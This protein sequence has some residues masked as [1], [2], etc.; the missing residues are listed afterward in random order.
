MRQ[1]LWRRRALGLLVA[2][3]FW[4]VPG[5]SQQDAAAPWPQPLSL[6]YVLAQVD[7]SHP[8]LEL[9]RAAVAQAQ[10]A[11]LDAQASY[12]F[13]ASLVAQLRWVDPPA[14]AP[15]QSQGDHRV[16]LYL[17]QRLYDFGRTAAQEA[18][19]AANVAGSQDRYRYALSQY[20]LAV[21][22]AFFDVILA[23]LEY[24]RDNEDM[25]TA[26]VQ[27]D[28]AK[29]RNELGQVS[30]I[31]LAQKETAYQTSRARRYASETRQ[32]TSRAALANI[33]NRPEQLPS[34]LARPK[35]AN[36]GR[37][38]PDV[39]PW[40]KTAEANNPLLL[41]LREELKGARQNLAAA[42][43][44][45]NPVLNGEVEVSRYARELGGYDNWRAGVTLD[46]PLVTG[47]STK[48]Q[49]ARR[50]AELQAVRAR[51]EQQRLAV[52]QAVLQ[53]WGDLTNLKAKREEVATLAGYR[54]LYLDRSRALYELE[55]KSD[56]G[57]AMVQ[58]SDVRLQ[59]ARTEF[60]IALT[61]AR[62]EALLGQTVFATKE[63]QQ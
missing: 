49:T 26:Y 57:D 34:D 16:S 9:A 46:V 59:M 39:E 13:N 18:A 32:R 58:T 11:Q 14:L 33:L 63:T 4:P 6:D 19:S 21:M 20:R 35:L 28:R 61:W 17:R 48:A 53:A 60:Q 56:L 41:A 37:D 52:R 55:V 27:Y 50:R 62:V 42:A 44:G 2:T 12:G 29:T 36:L 5:W 10:A 30:D 1:R 38:I 45:D 8:D 43:A 54:D 23:D 7:E 47:G 25:A 51:L 22:A 15:D 40:F 31:D 3:V 24:A